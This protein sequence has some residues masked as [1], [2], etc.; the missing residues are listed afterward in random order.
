MRALRAA[1]RNQME[2]VAAHSSAEVSNKILLAKKQTHARSLFTASS[3]RGKQPVPFDLQL[4]KAAGHES[5]Q[6][7]IAAFYR[8]IVSPSVSP[9][10]PP[11]PKPGDAGPAKSQPRRIWFLD[12]P[13]SP[14]E[15]K[16]TAGTT[17][18]RPGELAALHQLLL[19]ADD[20]DEPAELRVKTC[21]Q[22]TAT[23]RCAVPASSQSRDGVFAP[24]GT[25]SLPYPA[26]MS[27]L[28]QLPPLSTSGTCHRAR[29]RKDPVKCHCPLNISK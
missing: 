19:N 22:P 16:G 5:F 15:H 6:L 4:A 29:R 1:K 13:S 14:E 28:G 24:Q 9:S 25:T 20:K 10:P 18:P 8:G 2:T 23:A 27:F 11:P 26:G 21:P 12:M 17:H 7:R 3:T